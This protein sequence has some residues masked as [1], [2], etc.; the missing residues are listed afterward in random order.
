MRGL[1]RSVT[2]CCVERSTDNSN[3]EALSWVGQT[4][5]VLEMSK[6]ANAR[7][8][9]LLSISGLAN[10]LKFLHQ[11]NEFG[12]PRIPISL[13]ALAVPPWSIPFRRGCHGR[14]PVLASCRAVGST[15]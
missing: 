10:Q 7:E 5:C 15:E 4:L 2:D 8:R 11:R 1:T 14:T 12:L 3:V 13:Q 6:C 9:P